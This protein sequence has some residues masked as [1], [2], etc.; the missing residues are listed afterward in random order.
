M[1]LKHIAFDFYFLCC[2]FCQ[3][4]GIENV[5]N[6]PSPPD[7]LLLSARH[8]V[9]HLFA[10]LAHRFRTSEWPPLDRFSNARVKSCLKESAPL[11]ELLTQLGN[12]GAAMQ[13][14][15]R[16]AL[17]DRDIYAHLMGGETFAAAGSLQKSTSKPFG[18]LLDTWISTTGW[19]KEEEMIRG[20][21]ELDAATKNVT[22]EIR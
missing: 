2:S 20:K 4:H 22:L 8:T 5:F 9:P 17:L 16:E 6:K 18:S 3:N 7:S 11:L 1:R 21:S 14:V 15:L 13:K 12:M 10:H 19:L